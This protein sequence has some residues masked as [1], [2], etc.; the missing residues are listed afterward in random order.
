[1]ETKQV[2]LAWFGNSK[3]L[4]IALLFSLLFPIIGLAQQG[5]Y[6]IVPSLGYMYTAN[7]KYEEGYMK[8]N[9]E[10]VFSLAIMS[11]RFEMFDIE[12]NYTRL[13]S[14]AHFTP[15]DDLLGLKYNEVNTTI[16]HIQIGLVPKFI[17]G[18]PVVNPFTSGSVGT[19]I[20][21]SSE[22]GNIWRFSV[23]LGVGAEFSFT[24]EIGMIFRGRLIMPL[25]FSG[26]S[27]YFNDGESELG[28]TSHVS[29]LQYEL[30]T[31][32]IIKI[33]LSN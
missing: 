28:I 5:I 9:D 13:K 6:K 27:I 7:T 18:D 29:P 26:S 4:G 24:K 3:E 12:L 22:Y 1:M 14:K 30:G 19:S 11:S 8:I 2:D 33:G 25:V 20:Y 15:D 21:S 23:A 16:T 31:G 10:I 32:L 17:E